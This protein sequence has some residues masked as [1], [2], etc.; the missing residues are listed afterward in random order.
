LTKWLSAK[1]SDNVIEKEPEPSSSTEENNAA[2]SLF[3]QLSLAGFD[4]E[5]V[6]KRFKGKDT[7]YL[8]LLHRFNDDL[9]QKV[10]SLQTCMTNQDYQQG[11]KILHALKGIAGN[12]ALSEIAKTA[13][14]FELYLKEQTISSELNEQFMS[15]LEAKAEQFYASFKQL[16]IQAKKQAKSTIDA[17]NSSNPNNAKDNHLEANPKLTKQLEN[18]FNMLEHNNFSAAKLIKEIGLQYPNLNKETQWSE[19]N[20][21]I[22]GFDYKAAAVVLE[23]L[24]EQNKHYSVNK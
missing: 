19:I 10:K 14:E 13:V 2:G 18:L 22:N 20:S 17:S 1:V 8:D 23:K 16:K 21:L 24:L 9:M 4:S 11:K 15:S 12:L 7:L 6:L 5:V 3:E